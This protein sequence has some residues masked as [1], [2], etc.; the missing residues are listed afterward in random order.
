ME[1]VKQIRSLRSRTHPLLSYFQN[2]GSTVE[3]STLVLLLFQLAVLCFRVEKGGRK[4]VGN[5]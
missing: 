4:G 2:D 5:G 1:A 3:N